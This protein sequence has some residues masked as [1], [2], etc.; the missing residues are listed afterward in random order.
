MLPSQI[1]LD[2]AGGCNER[3]KGIDSGAEISQKKRCIVIHN[4]FKDWVVANVLPLQ[5][6]NPTWHRLDG[7]LSGGN[8]NIVGKFRHANRV[9]VVHGDT[10][11]DPVVRAYQAMAKGAVPDPFVIRYAKVRDCLDLLPKLKAPSQPK[12]FYVYS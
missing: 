5:K 4:S 1:G 12:Y 8:R 11:F 9:W 10:R 7:Q 3:Q 2:F 6:N